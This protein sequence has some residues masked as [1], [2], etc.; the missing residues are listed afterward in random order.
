MHNRHTEYCKRGD[1][2]FLRLL[3]IMTAFVHMQVIAEAAVCLTEPAILGGDFE[4]GDC[5]GLNNLLD[6][7]YNNVTDP[8]ITCEQ[9]CNDAFALVRDCPLLM[10]H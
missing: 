9:S 6:D 8:K 3:A 5:P 10:V 7:V 4:L 1:V 2:R